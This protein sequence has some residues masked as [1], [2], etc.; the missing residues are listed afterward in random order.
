[1]ARQYAPTAIIGRAL[2]L[3]LP[4]SCRQ[5]LLQPKQA[6]RHRW[7]CRALIE[8]DLVLEPADQRHDFGV[9]APFGGEEQVIS[10][11]APQL[12]APGDDQRS[13]CELSPHPEASQRRQAS[14]RTL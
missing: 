2:R 10:L 5:L 14:S 1:M 7:A 9:E 3:R 12:L 4:P 8:G 13:V 11:L 6:R